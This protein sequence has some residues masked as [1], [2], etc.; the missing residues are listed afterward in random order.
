MQRRIFGKVCFGCCSPSAS[1][2]PSPTKGQ[3]QI[4][5]KARVFC[6]LPPFLSL[7][8]WL[9][10]LLEIP[11]KTQDARK[12]GRDEGGEHKHG[13][14]QEA[15]TWNKCTGFKNQEQA[16]QRQSRNS[17]LVLRKKRSPIYLV[18]RPIDVSD[19]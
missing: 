12:A 5:K 9:G 14:L 3:K 15:C 18:I 11:A 1:L 10:S 8:F 2:K 19:N 4:E 6:W 7:E 16:P 17:L 13:L